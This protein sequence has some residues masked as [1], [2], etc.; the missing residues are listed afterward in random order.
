M[1]RWQIVK[2]FTMGAVIWFSFMLTMTL[3]FISLITK[4]HAAGLL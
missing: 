1:N 4:C 3:L 2:A